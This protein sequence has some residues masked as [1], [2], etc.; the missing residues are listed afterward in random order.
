MCLRDWKM[1]VLI[2]IP[3]QSVHYLEKP[4]FT[5]FIVNDTPVASGNLG[6]IAD[7]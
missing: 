1:M 2:Q 5:F 6:I 3:N 4:R 7:R